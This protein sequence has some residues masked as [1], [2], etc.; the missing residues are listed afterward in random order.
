MLSQYTTAAPL[1]YQSRSQTRPVHHDVFCRCIRRRCRMLTWP[2]VG[3]IP[4][5]GCTQA[6]AAIQGG[7]QF[8]D[9]Q[10]VTNQAT[11]WMAWALHP[12]GAAGGKKLYTGRG[13]RR[14]CSQ[15][16][17]GC[18]VHVVYMGFVHILLC[19]LLRLKAKAGCPSACARVLVSPP[20]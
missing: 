12:T 4:S 2:L 14:S 10:H 15:Q 5:H 8:S 1:A 9:A 11:A 7:S 19:K 18:E 17:F 6:P 20:G 16:R 3:G 13:W